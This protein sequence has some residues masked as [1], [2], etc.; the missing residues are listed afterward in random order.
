[1]RGGIQMEVFYFHAHYGYDFDGWQERDEYGFVLA[2]NFVNAM[3]QVV[4]YYRDDLMGVE[5]LYTGDTSII[6]IN[7][8]G[9]AEAFRKSYIKT[10][11]GEDEE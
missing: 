10:H 5:I 4:D 1:M 8:E 2:K 6:P 9:I 7:N 11:Y 3:E